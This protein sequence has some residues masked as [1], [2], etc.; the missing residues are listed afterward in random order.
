M[1]LQSKTKRSEVLDVFPFDRVKKRQQFR[2]ERS[3]GRNKKR[4]RQSQRSE[5]GSQV[6]A[7]SNRVTEQKKKLLDRVSSLFS[8]KKKAEV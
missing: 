7:H 1:T 2:S 8:K 4:K 6:E 3:H 5:I